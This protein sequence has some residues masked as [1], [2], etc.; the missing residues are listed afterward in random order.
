MRKLCIRVWIAIGSRAVNSVRVTLQKNDPS[1]FF[2]QIFDWD[3]QDDMRY[4]TSGI[5]SIDTV[6]HLMS[7]CLSQSEI[8]QK[9][10]SARFFA[11]LLST[12]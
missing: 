2:F 6:Y 4:D 3:G 1:Y 12:N 7:S 10:S 8:Y 11:M 5:T 9:N